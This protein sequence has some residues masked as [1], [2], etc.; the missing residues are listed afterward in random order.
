MA[1]N[2]VR[3]L[4]DPEG[5]RIVANDNRELAKFPD[6]GAAL[7]YCNRMG[8]AILSEPTPEPASVPAAAS[9]MQAVPTGRQPGAHMLELA[10][11]MQN[12]VDGIREGRVLGVAYTVQHLEP[13]SGGRT[14]TNFGWDEQPVI[15]L[16]G[17]E[18][19]KNRIMAF[20]FKNNTSE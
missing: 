6:Y 19:L 8:Y 5:T 20:L 14:E 10:N 16:G 4:Q 17:L 1:D 2:V 11:Q 15:V 3:L 13:G 9:P 18:V 12:V 7:D